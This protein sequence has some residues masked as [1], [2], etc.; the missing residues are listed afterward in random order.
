MAKT[1]KIKEQPMDSTVDAFVSKCFNNGE[2]RSISPVLN[3]VY[4]I[5]G[6]EYIFT[7]E[8]LE[9][10]LKKDDVIVKVTEKNVIVTG[11]LIE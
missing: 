5:N 11:L 1:K 9:N 4:T 8:V 3:N 2:V 10:I 6:I 7:E